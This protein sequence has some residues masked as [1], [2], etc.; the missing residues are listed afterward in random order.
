MHSLEEVSWPDG[1]WSLYQ[2]PKVGGT[3][4]RLNFFSVTIW[5]NLVD[6]SVSKI[7]TPEWSQ[8]SDSMCKDIKLLEYM[9]MYVAYN[10]V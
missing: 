8:E 9:Y 7:P 10:L 4:C 1:W 5:K 3:N 2:G 6:K